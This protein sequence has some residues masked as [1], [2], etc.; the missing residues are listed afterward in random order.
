MID[1]KPLDSVDVANANTFEKGDDQQRVVSGE[2]VHQ[3]KDVA[4][5]SV[6]EAHRQDAARQTESLLGRPRTVHEVLPSVQRLTPVMTSFGRLGNS[7]MSTSEVVTPS[8]VP[9]CES[10]PRVNSIMKNS[11]AQN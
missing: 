9:N 1:V 2:A 11:T 4:A 5:S 8:S 3:L 7:F 10:I 6:C